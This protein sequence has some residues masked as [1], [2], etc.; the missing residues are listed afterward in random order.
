MFPHHSA[1]GSP[2]LWNVTYLL[3]LLSFPPLPPLPLLSLLS[4]IP[5]FFP[6]IPSPPLSYPTL[7][8][9]L[10]P[11][12]PLP[13]ISLLS[14]LLSTL[15]LFRQWNIVL[16]VKNKQ[17]SHIKESD[18][19]NQIQF[20]DFGALSRFRLET[21]VSWE[22]ADHVLPLFIRFCSLLY[23]NLLPSTYLLSS[24]TQQV[25]WSLS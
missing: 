13:S 18:N 20:G 8:F 11:S 21:Q 9:P 3:I 1:W 5:L 23:N 4:P 12:P 15:I 6:P 24:E 19:V 7:S 25:L 16:V 14:P 22:L 2:S 10:V 17:K